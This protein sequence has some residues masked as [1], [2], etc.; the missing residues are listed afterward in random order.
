MLYII[1]MCI[2]HFFLLVIFTHCCFIFILDSRN[3]V[4]QKANLSNFFEFKGVVNQWRQLTT[5]TTHLAQELLINIQ[6]SD[7]SSSFVRDKN[8]ED[9]EHSGCL[10]EIDNDQLRGSL[11]F[12]LLQLHKLLPNSMFTILWSFSIWSK[13]ERRQSLVS[14]CLM[15]WLKKKSHFEVLS[16]LILC[17]NELFLDQTVMWDKK[18]ILYDNQRWPVQ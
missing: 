17:N 12:I 13:L 7:G 9:E 10:F 2:S 3:S 1:L 8:L 14:G 6:C 18:C 16:S 5:S 15:S 11:K 4:R